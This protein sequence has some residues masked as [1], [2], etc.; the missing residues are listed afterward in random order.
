MSSDTPET[1]FP[2][3]NR[4][5]LVVIFHPKR[6]SLIFLY[7]FSVVLII[8]GVGFM[9]AT[10]YGAIPPSELAW[11]MGSGAIIIGIL[12]FTTTEM[13]RSYTLYIITTWNVRVRKGIFRRKTTRLFYDEISECRTAIYPQEKRIGMGDVEICSSK[14]KNG[15]TIVFEEVENPDG[16]REIITRFMQTIPYPLHWD[17]IDRGS[18]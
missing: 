4:E 2:K 12:I 9:S 11:N 16:V 10:A 17:H 13:K 1:P 7:V 6:V 15:P 14:I 3:E 18:V 5:R 8:T